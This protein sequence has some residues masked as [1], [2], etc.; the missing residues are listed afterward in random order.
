MN[1]AVRYS[2]LLS[3]ALAGLLTLS[4]V[5][6]GSFTG[7]AS[8]QT[9]VQDDDCTF[10]IAASDKGKNWWMLS[11]SCEFSGWDFI[12]AR[13]FGLRGSEVISV[14]P[15]CK[16]Y[17]E[18]TWPG[19]PW[20]LQ[21]HVCGPTGLESTSEGFQ[22]LSGAVNLKVNPKAEVPEG[23][24]ARV[25]WVQLYYKSHPG[26]HGAGGLAAEAELKVPKK[27][28]EPTPTES[29]DPTETPEPTPTETVPTASPSPSPTGPVLVL[30]K[31]VTPKKVP[32]NKTDD[33]T[34]VGEAV[35]TVKVRNVG[36]AAY[37]G[38]LF[39]NDR[40]PDIW[41][42]IP[43]LAEAKGAMGFS[44]LG[45]FFNRLLPLKVLPGL[46]QG[47]P[48]RVYTGKEEFI[49][50]TEGRYCSFTFDAG[51]TKSGG[52]DAATSV[53]DWKG[54]T[55]EDILYSK[56]KQVH[57]L[58]GSATFDCAAIGR[59]EPGEEVVITI[60]AWRDEKDRFGDA[61]T[62]FAEAKWDGGEAKAQATVEL[63]GI[64]MRVIDDID[65]IAPLGRGSA[66]LMGAGPGEGLY[67]TEEADELT[68]TS[69]SDVLMGHYGDDIL[70]G[71]AGNDVIS[72]DVGDDE[73][74][75]GGGG[76]GLVGGSG[77]DLIDG[78]D[79]N[80]ELIGG[81]DK[82]RLIGGAGD[83]R[84]EA[85]D[86]ERDV[87]KCGPGKDVAFVDKKDEVKGCEKVR[88]K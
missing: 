49:S 75:G 67:G 26:L 36:N 19:Q 21:S 38:E 51:R 41:N 85:R 88:R 78:G 42:L 30:T 63:E 58:T 6:V 64:A 79:G 44:N 34:Y 76:D 11:A 86:G 56:S 55:F 9:V 35:W 77:K 15:E 31:T 27:W 59:L 50:G 25:L 71:L 57:K 1:P 53:D 83:D 28:I 32:E 7:A 29:P 87:V 5:A 12:D 52:M 81:P 23:Y 74:F 73:I 13:G 18:Q 65:Q 3:L 20:R 17:Y 48:A 60:N 68:G 69:R 14:P 8:G 10:S 2:T 66:R 43:Y 46:E 47:A 61:K 39:I 22:Y 84:I 16:E 80:D 82:D 45:V 40:L 72:G 37:E 54:L 33:P 70:R 24:N 62:N 4:M